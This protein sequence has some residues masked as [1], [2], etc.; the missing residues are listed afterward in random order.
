MVSDRDI[1]THAKTWQEI[2]NSEGDFREYRA[3]SMLYRDK[4]PLGK[5]GLNHKEEFLGICRSFSLVNRYLLSRVRPRSR[6]GWGLLWLQ[7]VTNIN[8]PVQIVVS[9][10]CA[11]GCPMLL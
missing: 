8:S 9:A 7:L 5:L 2:L 6:P 4:Q 1:L 3:K 10:V 11:V